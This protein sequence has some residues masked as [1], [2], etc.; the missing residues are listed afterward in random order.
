[1]AKRIYTTDG[2]DDFGSSNLYYVTFSFADGMNEEFQVGVGSD[3]FFPGGARKLYDSLHEGETGIL[4][5]KER[6]GVEETKRGITEL[7]KDR[8]FISFEK[9]REYGEIKLTTLRIN[10][11]T[12]LVL[13][14]L[15]GLI[16][17]ILFVVIMIAID[18]R[19]N[20][21]NWK[22]NRR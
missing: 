2:G 15:G 3:G 9:D 22:R 5:D 13:L 21:H 1:M 10:E 6:N 8:I 14:V 12:E 18:K 4:T 7:V 17:G 16:G 19:Q 20:P 11:V